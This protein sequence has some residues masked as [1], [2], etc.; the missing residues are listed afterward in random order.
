MHFSTHGLE[1]FM[2]MHTYNL[3]E[4]EPAESLLHLDMLSIGCLVCIVGCRARVYPYEV[5]A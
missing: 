1:L 2:A 3:L 4:I 5:T